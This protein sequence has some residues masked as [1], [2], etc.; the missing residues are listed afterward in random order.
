VR[1]LE[2]VCTRVAALAQSGSEVA[3]GDLGILVTEGLETAAL[4]AN[5]LH[6]ILDFCERE[7]LRRVLERNQGNR[8]RTARDLGISRQAL[9]HRLARLHKG[10]KREIG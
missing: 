9:Q 6:D 10:A 7:I 8:T 5:D 2:Q 3:P 1:E 4:P